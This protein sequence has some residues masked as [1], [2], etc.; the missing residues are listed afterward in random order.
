MNIEILA[1]IKKALLETI[2]TEV[3]EAFDLIDRYPP[4]D[5]EVEFRLGRVDD[6]F[7]NIEIGI[8]DIV[9][10]FN[11]SLKDLRELKDY[12]KEKIKNPYHQPKFN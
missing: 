3:S 5:K 4:G 10:E 11:E 6:C 9:F 7:H 12:I 1:P 2:K 8:K